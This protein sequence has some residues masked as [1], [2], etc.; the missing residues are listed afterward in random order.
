MPRL[1]DLHRP[2]AVLGSAEW[3]FACHVDGRATVGE[4]TAAS[5]VTLHDAIELVTRLIRAGLCTIIAVA[6][7]ALADGKP[8]GGAAPP[9]P[10][11]VRQAVP[12]V[13]DSLPARP[14]PGLL[15]QILDGLNSLK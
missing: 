11:R 1:C 13:A 14:D 3:A 6:A 4:L 10:R 9:L 12:S 2:S 15:R 7:P 8:A 5:G